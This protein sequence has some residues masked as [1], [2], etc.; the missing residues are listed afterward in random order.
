MVNKYSATSGCVSLHACTLIHEIL[1]I[2]FQYIIII[3]LYMCIHLYIFYCLFLNT[4]T[5]NHLIHVDKKKSSCLQCGQLLLTNYYKLTPYDISLYGIYYQPDKQTNQVKTNNRFIKVHQCR[6]NQ[7]IVT[8]T[9]V[10]ARALHF[11]SKILHG[12]ECRNYAR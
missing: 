10:I 5:C 7:I 2:S 1:N 3:I 6:K 9:L 8:V 12:Q 4:Y 11:P